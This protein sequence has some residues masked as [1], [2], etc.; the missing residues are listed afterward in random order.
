M[1]ALASL[2]RN[3]S[4]TSVDIVLSVPAQVVGHCHVEEGLKAYRTLAV[5]RGLNGITFKGKLGD[6]SQHL[7]IR[8]DMAVSLF[9]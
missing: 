6:N 4:H 8:K 3:F 2:L 9:G 7:A 1:T 5:K